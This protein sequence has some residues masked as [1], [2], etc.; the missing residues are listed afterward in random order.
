MIIKQP[1]MLDVYFDFLNYT[2][3]VV[4]KFYKLK[5]KIN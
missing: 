2:F 5:N 4:T 3:Y 1:K